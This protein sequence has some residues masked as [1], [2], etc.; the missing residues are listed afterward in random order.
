MDWT[1]FEKSFLTGVSGFFF[2]TFR[3]KVMKP[4]PPSA[5]NTTGCCTNFPFCRQ[6]DGSF[7]VSSGNRQKNHA[8]PVN[9]VY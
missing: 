1:L 8:N 3:K 6:A 9:P 7:S 4:N 5:E 2:I